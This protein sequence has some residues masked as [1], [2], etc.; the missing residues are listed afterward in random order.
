MPY[1]VVVIGAGP[2]GYVAAIRAAQ[3]GA[4]VALVEKGVLGGTCL[5]RGC[6]PTKALA[7]GVS[8]LETV[9]RASRFGVETGAITVDFRKLTERKDQVVGSLVRGVEYLLK[10]NRVD[11]FRG[12]GRLSGQGRVLIEG[13]DGV[14]IIEA[15]NVILATGTEP[16]VDRVFGYDGERV[17]TSDE[18]LGLSMVPPRF[19]I[20]GGGVIGC[21]FACIFASLGSKVTIVEIMPTILPLLDGEVVRR[22]QSLLKR[23]GIVI[24]TGVKILEIKK[25][26]AVVAVLEGGEELE[27]DRV[28]VST[29]RTM[30]LKGLGVEE[31][32]VALGDRGEVL[33]NDRMQTSVP[34]IYAVGDI[35]GG[36]QLAHVASAQGMAAAD[37]IMGRSRPVDYGVVPACIY[38]IPEVGS[39]GMT[40]REAEEKGIRVKAGKFPFMAGGKA[41]A[42]GETGGFVK[43]LADFDTDRIV[44]VH[45]I[46][47][48][49][50]ELIAEAAVAMQM[51]ATAGQ[52]AQTIHAHPTLAETVMEA[53][54]AVHGMS[55][56]M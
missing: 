22:M 16:A 32:G 5:N 7:A 9:R 18:A 23:R 24:K 27:A 56:H 40:A 36:M 38:T 54:G 17:I 39:V 1:K 48:H 29:G 4:R 13:P 11:L 8:V 3:L 45:I 50:T 19:L 34:G 31:A 28:L 37:D 30:N 21:E 43:I 26:D 6:I 12:E 46:G 47:P 41:Q 2:G 35:V 51:G 10:K 25:H 52:L 33:V 20:I 14:R 53:A 55:I 42:M 49:A 15:E 44:G